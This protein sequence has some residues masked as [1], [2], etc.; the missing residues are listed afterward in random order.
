MVSARNEPTIL[1]LDD[2]EIKWGW[3]ESE[4]LHFRKLWVGGAPVDE[5]ARE[6]KTNQRSV[7]LLVM[8][9]EM[10]REIGKRRFG[11]WGN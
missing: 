1:I 2:P 3:K 9:Q 6:L 4:I 8:D 7:A 10:K 5:M 11:L